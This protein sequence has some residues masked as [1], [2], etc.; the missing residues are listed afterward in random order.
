DFHR[1]RGAMFIVMEYVEG[2]DLYDLLER[3][4]RLPFDVAAVVAMQ[5]ARALDYIH[6]RA[7][8]RRDIKPANRM[9]SRQGAVKLM[10]FGIAQDRSFDDRTEAGTGIGTPAY[11]SPE[12]ILGDR[13][14]ARSD[15]FS[16]GIVL[17]QMITGRK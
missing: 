5:V 17:Y 9:V 1:E 7:I 2:I 16:L 14:D 12:Q 10:D 4:G 11:M 13:I 8:L 15:I 3:C 6:Y